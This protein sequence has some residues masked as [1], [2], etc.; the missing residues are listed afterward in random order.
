MQC[1]SRIRRTDLTA[2]HPLDYRVQRKPLVAAKPISTG[3]DV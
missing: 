2:T 1:L 3:W